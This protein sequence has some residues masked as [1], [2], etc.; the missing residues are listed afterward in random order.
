MDAYLYEES[1]DDS[2]PETIAISKEVLYIQ[3]TNSGVYNGQIVFDTSS[4]SNSGK[5]LAWSQAELQIPFIVSFTSAANLA[6]GVRAAAFTMGL[7]NGYY[8]I[9]DSLQI[10]YNNVNIQQLSNNLNQFVNYKV[11][12][13]W[14]RSDLDKWSS[15]YGV[16]PDD[17]A[18]ASLNADLNTA[19]TSG[20]GFPN[21]TDQIAAASFAHPYPSNTGFYQRQIRNT[22]FSAVAAQP[23]YGNF[24]SLNV[25]DVGKN[26]YNVSGAGAGAVYYYVILCTIPLSLL[27]D[28]M[29][30][31]P[32]LRG[33]FFRLTINY[34][35][36]SHSITTVGNPATMTMA[37]TTILSGRTCPY[38][39]AS[40]AAN[41]GGNTVGTN[42]AANGLTLSCGVARTTSIASPANLP[43]SSCR[44]YVPAY[45]LDP[46]KEAQL[47]Q[48]KPIRQVNYT[49]IYT[50]TFSDSGAGTNFNQLITNGIAGMKYLVLIPYAR[51]SVAQG[52]AA[53]TNIPTA[54]L[55][56]F[57]TFPGTGSTPL[58][59]LSN[60]N[61]QV[62]GRNIFQ[63]NFQ[64]DFEFFIN[65]VA[66][67]N[68]INGGAQWGLTSGLIDFAFWQNAYRYYVVNLERR[69]S[70][71]DGVPKSVQIL[72]KNSSGYAMDYTCIIVYD[73]KVSIDMTEARVVS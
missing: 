21:N 27:S 2:K 18:Y 23:G 15:M 67:M 6:A 59:A 12:S 26:H 56:P 61:V 39:I 30:K 17:P 60:F 66:S 33:G 45:E 34:N 70:I 62:G 35:S 3:D 7:K 10:D 13:T 52:G 5:W 32:L 16:Y 1:L 73:R 68:A 47:L 50:Y 44:L 4:L 14:S 9:I 22:A 55:S 64:Y 38:L 36:C 65:E 40:T 37:S 58:A 42:V 8:Q 41:N 43:F 53:I 11:L 49:D 57:D 29:A 31:A 46:T 69:A 25:A 48:I 71:E 63:Q 24:A 54:A 72:G 20:T 19:S 51:Y 28:F